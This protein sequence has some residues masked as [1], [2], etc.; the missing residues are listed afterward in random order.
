MVKY[1][2]TFIVV[3]FNG[4]AVAQNT[5]PAGVANTYSLSEKEGYNGFLYLP[6]TFAAD[7]TIYTSVYNGNT[8]IHGN[9]YLIN[10]DDLKKL[11]SIN[12]FKIIDSSEVWAFS[13][14]S[15][16]VI[17]NHNIIRTV[18]LP[19]NTYSYIKK[20]DTSGMYFFAVTHGTIGTWFFNG[21]SLTKKG[22]TN[23]TYSISSGGIMETNKNQ[24]IGEKITK[25]L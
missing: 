2:L 19:D 3:L 10:F 17:K 25:C 9:N 7:G 5:F 1:L 11:N 21:A 23:T 24:N 20:N 14:K 8:E 22:T 16:T 12:D 15:V 6:I 18:K 13:L 4:I